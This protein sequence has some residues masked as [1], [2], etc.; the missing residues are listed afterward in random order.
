MIKSI[1][2]IIYNVIRIGIYKLL[3]NK[4]FTCSPIQRINPF[5]SLKLYKKGKM[6][7][8]KNCE[9]EHGCDFQV[10]DNATLKI[11][12]RTYFNRYCM[13][14]AHLHIE[15]GE[16]CMFGPGVKIFD[17]NHRFSKKDGVLPQL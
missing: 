1:V 5:C 3:Y 9:F 10:H 11:G 15:I 13:I 7:I 16:G 8:G 2:F 17:N 12:D 14:S 4:R 6:I